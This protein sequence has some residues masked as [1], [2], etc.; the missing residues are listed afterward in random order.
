M[1]TSRGIQEMFIRIAGSVDEV[2]LAI[3]QRLSDG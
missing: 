2:E 1:Q 3:R